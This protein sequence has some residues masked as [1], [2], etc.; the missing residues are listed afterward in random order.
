MNADLLVDCEGT[1]A[2]FRQAFPAIRSD[3]DWW[4]PVN[5][6]L[7]R[8]GDTLVLVDTGAGP[9]P[10]AFLPDGDAALPAELARAGV[11]PEDVDVVVH[12]HLHIDHDGWTGSF[13]NAR[14]VVYED[15]WAY[16]M[17]EQSL[18][19][20]PHLCEKV[21]PLERVERVT[22]ETEVAPGVHVQPAPATRRG[23]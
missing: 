9:K 15:D 8:S 5:C 20:R 4:L 6:A 2:T 22:G 18:A 12:T 10:R 19:E 16:F 11:Q 1:F 17:S 7:P 3:A 13:P 23:T 14:N 21:L